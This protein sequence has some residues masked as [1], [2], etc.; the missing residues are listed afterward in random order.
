MPSGDSREAEGACPVSETG[1][2]DVAVALDAWVRSPAQRM[3]GHVRIDDIAVEIVTE[4]EHVVL[5][6]QSIRYPSSII[7]VGHRAAAGVRLPTPQPQRDSNHLVTGVA[8]QRCG[9]RRVDAAR[10]GDHDRPQG[11]LP[12]AV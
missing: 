10:H 12:S 5:D 11:R 9:Y 6:S 3:V 7:D 8:E 1:E 4:V 2:L